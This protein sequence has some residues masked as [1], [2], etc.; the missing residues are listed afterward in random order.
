[1]MAGT[2]S[3][4][5]DRKSKEYQ[6]FRQKY[7]AEKFD[8]KMKERAWLDP[9]K[10]VS[11][12]APAVVFLQFGTQEDFLTPERDR[13][14]AAMVSEPKKF[15]LYEAPHALNAEAR[16]DRIAFLTEQLGLK[17]LPEAVIAAVPDLPQPPAP[18]EQ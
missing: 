2:L 5:V 18:K 4:E 9:G 13:E 1:M 17:A 7:G 10:Y 8:A 14:Y 6:E 3:D 16:R 11:H 12:A 15:K